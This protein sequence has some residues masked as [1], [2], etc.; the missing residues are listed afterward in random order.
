MIAVPSAPPIAEVINETSSTITIQWLA[1][2]PANGVI[3]EYRITYKADS[4]EGE[5]VVSH[6][7]VK[8][9][10]KQLNNLEA[11]TVYTIRVRV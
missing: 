2:S 3:T 1:P 4:E 8:K 5:R 7:N 10:K 6:T 9:L 11:Y